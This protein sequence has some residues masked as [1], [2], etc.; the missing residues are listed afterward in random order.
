MSRIT[1]DV[2]QVQQAVSETAGDFA[3]E[4]LA[5]VGYAAPDVLPGRAA[6]PRL[7]DRGAAH[8]V[9]AHPARPARAPHHAPQPGGARAALAHQ[10]RGVHG[11][12]HRQSVRDRGARGREIQPRGSSPVPDQH[13]GHGGAVHPAAADGA[14]RRH[15]HGRRALVRRAADWHRTPDNRSVRVVLRR[16][17]SDV[18]TGEEAEPRERES[19]TGDCR[20]RA[21]LRHARHAHGGVRAAGRASRSR[22]SAGRSSSPRSASAT[23]RTRRGFCAACRLRSAPDRWWRLS[24]GAA[25]ARPRS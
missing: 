5:L 24:A 11:P 9:P 4:S 3:R 10:R 14:A 12:P 2:G 15:R 7:H 16:R 19:P 23:T 22:P 18:R 21:D 25:R 17:L 1:N 8:R 20:L 6:G 13:E